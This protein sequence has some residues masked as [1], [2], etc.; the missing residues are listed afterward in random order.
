MKVSFTYPS[1]AKTLLVLLTVFFS[2]GCDTPIETTTPARSASLRFLSAL[3]S[4]ESGVLISWQTTSETEN[5][6][7]MVLRDGNTI[8]SY[9]SDSLLRGA[10][11]STTPVSYSFLD[12]PSSPA[13]RYTLKSIGRDG[14]IST[15]SQSVE[16]DPVV[17]LTPRSY[18]LEQ[19]FPNP[20]DISTQIRFSLPTTSLVALTFSDS[21]GDYLFDAI[22]NSTMLGGAYSIAIDLTGLG[23]G[24]YFYTM[25][26][27]IFL[28][29]KR[30]VIIR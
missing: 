1:F 8:A 6:G 10:G 11:N 17:T 16:N 26:T 28:E 5:N 4:S 21:Q 20:T 2:A 25:R 24:V 19:N 29:S 13:H 27:P 22:N 14:K 18:S 30:L 3:S 23:S 15:Y 7:F 9:E 12:N